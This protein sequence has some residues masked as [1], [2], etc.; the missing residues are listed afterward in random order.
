VLGGQA[1]LL[2]DAHH[3]DEPAGPEPHF[4]EGGGD[5]GPTAP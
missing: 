1:I 2:D 3:H 5:A 4:H